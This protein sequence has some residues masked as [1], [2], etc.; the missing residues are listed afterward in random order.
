M[1]LIA[2]LRALRERV[3]RLARR[4]AGCAN[5]DVPSLAEQADRLAEAFARAK[6][7]VEASVVAGP[8]VDA[9]RSKGAQISSGRWQITSPPTLSAQDGWTK[10]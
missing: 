6:R 9:A 7:Y 1:S 3:G 5:R 4:G 2:A 10:P 8:T